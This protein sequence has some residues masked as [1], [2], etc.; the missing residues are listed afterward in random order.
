MELRRVGGSASHLLDRLEHAAHVGQAATWRNGAGDGCSQRGGCR[1]YS[2]RQAR[3]ARI[4]AVAGS[5]EKLA[6]TKSL[7]A[8]FTINYKDQDVAKE[9]KKITGSQGVDVVFEH[10]GAA[11]WQHA[12]RSMGIGARLVTCGATTGP[13]VEIDLRFF[14]SRQYS[15]MGCHMGSRADLLKVL[16]LIERKQLVPVIDS[17]YPL[18]EARAAQERLETMNV[19]GKIVVT[20]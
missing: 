3:R 19:I 13:K 1:S 14:F 5:A 12:M 20:V 4:I 18:E 7:G 16:Q 10:V 2:D 17:T 9:V 6:K 11:L 8:D 15:I